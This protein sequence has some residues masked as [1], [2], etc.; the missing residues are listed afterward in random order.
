MKS[1]VSLDL[2]D[3]EWLQIM[4]DLEDLHAYNILIYNLRFRVHLIKE[5]R[6]LQLQHLRSLN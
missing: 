3:I 5:K 6:A 1:V 4:L 2:P